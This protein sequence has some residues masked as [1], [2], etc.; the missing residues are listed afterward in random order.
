VLSEEQITCQA[1]TPH[2]HKPHL[3]AVLRQAVELCAV[4]PLGLGLNCHVAGHHR[5]VVAVVHRV[6]V[7]PTPV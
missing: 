4:D 7:A 6:T 2:L 3:N 1:I 5:G